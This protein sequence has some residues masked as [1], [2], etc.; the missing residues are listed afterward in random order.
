METNTSGMATKWKALIVIAIVAGV[1]IGVWLLWPTNPQ[2]VFIF[3]T[4][5]GPVD[6][7][8]QFAWD[9]ASSD[10]IDQVCEGLYGYNFSIASPPVIP[11]LASDFGTWSVDGFNY[12][13][14]LRQNVM[15]HDG[16]PFN[17]SAVKWNFDRLMNFLNVTGTLTT[18][19]VT[20][21]EPIYIIAGV[22]LINR[23]EV[24][25][26][27][28]IKF[29]LSES[30]YVPFTAILAFS[31]S[32]IQSPSS[33]P[34][35]TYLITATSD[36]VGTGAYIYDSYK[37]GQE[38]RFHA[39]PSYWGGKPA[40]DILIFNIIN[41]PTARN[42]AL[43]TGAVSFI[44]DPLPSM[45]ATFQSPDSGVTVLNA[46]NEL[47]TR[48]ISFNCNLINQ[49][50]RNALSYSINYTYVLDSIMLGQAVR[51][52][53]PIVAGIPYSNYS[54][55]IPDL[56]YTKAREIMQSMGYG[57]GLSVT[58]DAAWVAQANSAPFR[59]INYTYNA[60][61]RIREEVGTL[62]V[63]NFKH[64]GVLCT[65]N[66]EDWGIVNLK[67]QHQ[68]G[69]DVNTLML[70]CIG[71]G[72][73][74]IDASNFAQPLFQT[75][76]DANSAQFSNATIDTLMNDALKETNPALR[77]Q[78]YWEFQRL[79]VEE[80]MPY[81]FLYAPIQLDAIRTSI[82]GYHVNVMAKNQF[83]TCAPASI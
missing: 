13:V 20:Q 65:A 61:N 58:N 2:K 83:W 19:V 59:T 63:E 40:Y 43:L 75:G 52:K 25:D 7:D 81:A 27:Y 45:L 10:V 48:Y 36:L 46:G 14:P 71:W 64:I 26:T 41:D 54:F 66:A 11:R 67:L 38:V 8:P 37:S 77:E 24:V 49:T 4:S 18:D 60:G 70:L 73:D 69:Y 15:F 68:E 31:G 53:S 29:V 50:W 6:L 78:D 57:L 39:N 82:I 51:L 56:N 5:D 74:Y 3:G 12:T 79:I 23:T 33:T 44:A 9:Q 32:Y 34:Y 55:N 22:P 72:A 17:A 35:G 16:T 21:L 42:Q 1:G 28:T 47:G 30:F 80:Q 76:S 62:V